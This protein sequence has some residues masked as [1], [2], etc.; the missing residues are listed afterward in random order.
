MLVYNVNCY[1][2]S[3]AHEA[4]TDTCYCFKTG[5]LEAHKKKHEDYTYL[6]GDPL[7]LSV[8]CRL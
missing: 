8:C 4:C 6:C 5:E 1:P 2:L 7:P 3:V